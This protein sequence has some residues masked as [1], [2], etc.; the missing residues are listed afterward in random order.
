MEAEIEALKTVLELIK[1]SKRI[2]SDYKA[3]LLDLFSRVNFKIKS[4]AKWWIKEVDVLAKKGAL[5]SNLM[6]VYNQ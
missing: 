2:T 6:H 4:A 1:A 3:G 5:K